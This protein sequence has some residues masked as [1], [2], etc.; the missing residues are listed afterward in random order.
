MNAPVPSR[1]QPVQQVADALRKRIFACPPGEQIGSLNDL[2]REL[3][4]GIVS[5]QQA[6]RI[7][8]FEGLLEVRR[9][10]GGGYFGRRPDLA[11]LEQT[12]SA[13][14]RSEPARSALSAQWEAVTPTHPRPRQAL[15]NAPGRARCCAA[16]RLRRWLDAGFETT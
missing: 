12:I 4:V 16:A 5:V 2:A 13:Y 15:Q 7:L 3:G 1:R 6:A 8:E 9:G 10:P 14:W 11:T